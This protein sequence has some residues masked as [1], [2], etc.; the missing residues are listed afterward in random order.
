MRFL[1]N[2]AGKTMESR[3][4]IFEKVM[5][6]DRYNI[7]MEIS[8]DE[9]WLITH[10]RYDNASSENL[11]GIDISIENVK[12][13]WIPRVIHKDDR[14]VVV[15]CFDRIMNGED[16]KFAR[17]RYVTDINIVYYTVEIFKSSDNSVFICSSEWVRES[18]RDALENLITFDHYAEDFAKPSNGAALGLFTYIR[19]ADTIYPIEISKSICECFNINKEQLLAYRF[20]G[21]TVSDCFAFGGLSRAGMEEFIYGDVDVCQMDIAGENGRKTRY[22]LKKA[23]TLLE[24]GKEVI[25][26]SAVP[27]KEKV[28]VRTF[29][30]FGVFIYDKPVIFSSPKVKEMLAVLVDHRGSFVS[31]AEMNE[32]LWPEEPADERVMNRCRKTATYLK[33]DLKKYGIEDIIESVRGQRRIR[34]ENITCDLYDYL[35][36]EDVDASLRGMYMHRYSW[37]MYTQMELK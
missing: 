34:P 15:D 13:L 23:V 20:T 6:D 26:A 19:D 31:N 21:M 28:F 25:K 5:S 2:K 24:D 14:E 11:T 22:T 30:V 9:R 37:G 16:I 35:E 3:E 7:I 8:I 18:N 27:M 29:G 32:L 17:Y 1:S 36:G 33:N 12:K 4:S 10:K